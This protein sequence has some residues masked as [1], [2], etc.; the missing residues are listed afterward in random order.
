DGEMFANN[1][2]PAPSSRAL[3]VSE[4]REP[5]PTHVQM[6]GDF[7][8]PG[9][10]VSPGTPAFLPPLRSR[11]ARAD[12]SDLA[13][14][15][16]EPENPLTPRGAVNAIWQQPFGRGLVATPENFGIQGEP[17]TH[18]E[19]LDWL[20]V[21]LRESGWSRKRLIRMIV[22]SATYRQSSRARADL[23]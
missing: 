11:N 18:P 1:R 20:A 15:L 22:S 12:R 6:R 16:V 8:S 17:P 19:L 21:E 7:Q 23:A 9:E 4:N 2:P 14:W 5:R 10:V 3:T 13:R